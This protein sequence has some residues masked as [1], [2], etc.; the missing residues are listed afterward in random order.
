MYIITNQPE[1][2]QRTLHDRLTEPIRI[3]ESI[4]TLV[5]FFYMNGYNLIHRAIDENPDAKM[6]ILVGLDISRADKILCEL[7]N[8]DNTSIRD[9]VEAIETCS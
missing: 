9:K 7:E 1:E 6:R 5:G 3:S 4:D 8:S 2:G